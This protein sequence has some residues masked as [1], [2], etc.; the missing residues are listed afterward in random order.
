MIIQGD[1]E[2]REKMRA[3]DAD[4]VKQERA[5]RKADDALMEPARLAAR[6]LSLQQIETDMKR[7]GLS[8]DR[9]YLI[10][11]IEKA[12]RKRAAEEDDPFY[13]VNTEVCSPHLPAA[14]S[15]GFSTAYI[16]VSCLTFDWSSLSSC[17]CQQSH[18]N[19]VQMAAVCL[20][21]GPLLAHS[22]QHAALPAVQLC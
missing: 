6:G 19:G 17:T 14:F 15:T 8:F 11:Q 22:L 7:R 3:M 16:A 5:Q 18:A 4:K 20:L 21:D 10:R 13:A 9:D 2:D 1:K 12:D